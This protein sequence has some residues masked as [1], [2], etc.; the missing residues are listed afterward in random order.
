MLRFRKMGVFGI[1]AIIM[2]PVNV[3]LKAVF[4]MQAKMLTILDS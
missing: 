3:G 4:A 1:L 2:E